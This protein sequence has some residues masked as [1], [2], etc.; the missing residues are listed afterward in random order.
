[1]YPEFVMLFPYQNSDP[2]NS[3]DPPASIVVL[4]ITF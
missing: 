2:A 1:M 3:T 4:D